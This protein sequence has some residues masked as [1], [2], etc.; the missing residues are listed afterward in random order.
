[1][2]FLRAPRCLIG[3][4]LM[5]L[6]MATASDTPAHA[7]GTWD[8]IVDRGTIRIGVIPARPPY[9]WQEDGKWVGF[10]AMMGSDLASAFGKEVNKDIHVEFVVTSWTSVILDIQADKIDAFFG[11]NH[12]EERDKAINLVG[13]LYSLPSVVLKAHGVERED[14]WEAFNKPDVKIAVVMGTT[15]EKVAREKLPEAQIRALKGMG[16]A[17]L[18]IQ[19]RNADAM[20][21]T[22]LTGLGA[23]KENKSIGSMAILQPVRTAPSFGGTRRDGDGRFATF[24]Q[25]W[26]SRYR[27]EGNPKRVILEAMKKFGLDTSQ[28]PPGMEF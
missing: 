21:T 23:L 13:P 17:V 8:E 2:T 7:A 26:A 20:V 22:V 14:S 11:L 4:V 5:L 24:M 3:A 6:A 28:L 16:E 27:S 18:D 25:D 12:S 10:S 1:M 9:F 19:S 15:D